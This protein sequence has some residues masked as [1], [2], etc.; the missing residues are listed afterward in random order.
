MKNNPIISVIVAFYN[1]GE[2][3]KNS[4]ESLKNQNNKNFEAIFINDGSTD[5]SLNILKTYLIE[6][7]FDYKVINKKNE[8]VS[9]ARNAGIKESKGKYV[10]FLDADDFI[11]KSLIDK[12]INK[13]NNSKLAPDLIYWGWDKINEDK[14]I[15]EKY[16]NNYKYIENTDSLLIDYMLHRIWIWTGSAAYRKNFLIENNIFFPEGV[17][18]TEDI[19]FI[20]TSL[21]KA[22][23]VKCIPK[24]LSFYCIHDDSISH[25]YTFKRIHT[26]KAMYL[27][28]ESLKDGSKEKEIFLNKFKPTFYWNMINGLLFFDRNDHETKKKIIRLI[29]NKSIRKVLKKQRPA[30]IRHKIRNILIIYF[31]RFY[32][33]FIMKERNGG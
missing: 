17:V 6:C 3:I 19:V 28:E 27:L 9:I 26:I 13:L 4:L 31:P 7:D 12:I 32:K 25:K 30:K 23:T 11:D 24:S 22:K 14:V 16:E 29:K 5:Q 15:F 21:L 18:I 33:D 20:F 1:S 2:R 8:G 10:Y